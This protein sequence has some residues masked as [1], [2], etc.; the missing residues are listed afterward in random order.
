[1]VVNRALAN[2]SWYRIY[3]KRVLDL[4]VSGG[5]V[6]LVAPLFLVVA[7]LIR[8]D[9]PGPIFHRTR[10]LAKGGGEYTLLKFRT[11]VPN[12]EQV[13]EQLLATDGAVRQ[14]YEATYKIKNDPR[15]TRIGR[16][17]R[18]W[19]IDELPQLLNVL[20][21][22]MSLVGPR[23]ILSSEIVKYGEYGVKLITVR[24][25]ITGLW[26]VSGRSRLSYEERVRLDMQYIDELSLS[27]DLSILF[28]TP[29]AVISGDGAV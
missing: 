7:L 8:L 16:F 15:V 18:R 11:M 3:G 13:L 20:M 25:G 28:K 27:M 21:G 17:L 12:A 19:S 4:L 2:G 26:Q 23:Q 6:I 29:R 14:E 22:D 10:R 9:S 1:M 5:L 24:P